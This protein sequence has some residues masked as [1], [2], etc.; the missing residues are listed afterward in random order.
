MLP[1]QST[2]S[3]VSAPSAG[4]L[5]LQARALV[6][7]EQ[8]RAAAAAERLRST[9]T[10]AGLAPEGVQAAAAA[11]LEER[12]EDVLRQAAA[13]LATTTLHAQHNTRLAHLLGAAAVAVAVAARAAAA[14]RAAGASVPPCWLPAGPLATKLCLVLV[15]CGVEL[16]E[17]CKRLEGLLP[18][19][20]AALRALLAALH[21]YQRQLGSSELADSLLQ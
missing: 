9:R 4:E 18:G 5:L 10:R 6:L 14:A 12:L 11:L 13:P 7:L 15:E 19:E 3:R 8:R 17:A 1:A 2:Q 21:D 20:D 16:P